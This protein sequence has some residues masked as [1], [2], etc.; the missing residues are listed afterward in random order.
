MLKFHLQQ[1]TIN[2]LD[3]WNRNRWCYHYDDESYVNGLVIQ[4]SCV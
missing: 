2:D 4:R 1:G 3:D